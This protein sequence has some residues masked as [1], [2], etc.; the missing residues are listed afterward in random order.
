MARL[1]VS[2]CILTLL[3][4]MPALAQPIGP[5]RSCAPGQLVPVV[6]AGAPPGAALLLSWAGRIVGGGVVHADG[7]YTLTLAVGRERPGAYEVAV[8]VRDGREVLQRFRCVVPG[9]GVPTPA[10]TTPRTVAT[11]GG[12]ATATLPQQTP[13]RP[14]GDFDILK[15]DGQVTCED[16]RTQP[17]A[18]K[19][20][21]AGYTDL[22]GNDRDGLACESLPAQ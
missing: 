20:Y 10:P 22:D 2:C 21:E 9:A 3:L 16:F 13:T 18:Q 17:E 5:E 6:G 14:V 11:P 15:P 1:L 4:T 8:L 19:A 12:A 7:R